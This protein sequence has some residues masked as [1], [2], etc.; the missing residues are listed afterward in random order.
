[1][2]I[3]ECGSNGLPF[4]APPV[5]VTGELSNR[6][7]ITARKASAK[8]SAGQAVP[9]VVTAVCGDKKLEIKVTVD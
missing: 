7:I 4:G 9:S 2:K 3:P 1:M 6:G 5:R 8:D